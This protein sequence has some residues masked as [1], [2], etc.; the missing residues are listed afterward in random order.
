M[1]NCS[2]SLPLMMCP[3]FLMKANV[4]QH[5]DSC[6]ILTA[7]NS[8]LRSRKSALIPR[9]TVEALWNWRKWRR[10]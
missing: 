2:C 10:H 8:S 1:M 6:H 3:L 9:W 5:L 7:W 4:Q